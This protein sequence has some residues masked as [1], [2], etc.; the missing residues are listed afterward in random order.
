MIGFTTTASRAR[1]GSALSGGSSSIDRDGGPG[2]PATRP[3]VGRRAR[4]GRRYRALA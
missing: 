1:S 3:C 4:A 2:R